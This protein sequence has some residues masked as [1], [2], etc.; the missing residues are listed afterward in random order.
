MIRNV[1]VYYPDLSRIL[2]YLP[3]IVEVNI[4]TLTH[5]QAYLIFLLAYLRINPT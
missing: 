4:F 1:L 5:S 2:V 3:H